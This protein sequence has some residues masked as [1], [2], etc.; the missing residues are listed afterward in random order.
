MLVRL[1]VYTKP[2]QHMSPTLKQRTV[3]MGAQFG[4]SHVVLADAVKIR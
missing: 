4:H 1:Y 2:V 3:E